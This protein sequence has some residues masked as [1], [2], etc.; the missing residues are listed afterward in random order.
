MKVLLILDHAPDYREIFLRELSKYV[1]LTVVAQPCE[2]D[3]LAPPDNRSGYFYAQLPTVRWLGINFQPGL[4]QLLGRED[5][6]V[7]CCDLNL[8]HPTRLFLFLAFRAYRRKWIWRGHIYGKKKSI[9]LQILKKYLLQ[10]GVGCL[11][12]SEPIAARVFSDFGVKSFSF[13]NTQVGENDF[14][15]GVFEEHSELRFLFVGRNQPRKKLK[16]LISLV[17]RHKDLYVRFIGP[18]ME[19]LDVPPSLIDSGNVKIFGKM[20]GTDLI[21]HFN[22]ADIVAN[23]GHVGL[24][25]I[26]AAK[27]GKGIIIDSK[28]H[29]APEY[30]I[31]K[32]S[33][34]PF[35]SF[36]NEK[37]VDR[38]VEHVRNNRWRLKQWGKQLQNVAKQ[39]YT[40]EYMAKVH[41]QAFKNTIA[42]KLK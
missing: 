10:N 31:A 20:M 18:G 23:P 30:W 3:G 26:N 4:K 39:K 40:I 35:I 17:Q 36:D 12:Y 7:V 42:Y 6:D 22:W 15:S 32:E 13:N 9:G 1:D 41:C 8:R 34:Q 33:G 19:S 11:A 16:R 27:H 2:R 38:F 14:L 21:A 25:T 37:V 29:H 28:S 24:L 5:W